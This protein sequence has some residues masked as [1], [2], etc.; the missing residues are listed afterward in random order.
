MIF[1]ELCVYL[2]NFIMGSIDMFPNGYSS[3]IVAQLLGFAL[4]DEEMLK[5]S[6]EKLHD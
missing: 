3:Y 5:K 6:L 4:K 1:F 2:H